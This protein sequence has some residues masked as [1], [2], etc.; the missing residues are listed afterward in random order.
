M[1]EE[2]AEE[3]TAVTDT[4]DIGIQH[5]HDMSFTNSRNKQSSVASTLWAT[6]AP[7]LEH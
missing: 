6:L 2:E 3:A 1:E 4:R 7:L 5:P